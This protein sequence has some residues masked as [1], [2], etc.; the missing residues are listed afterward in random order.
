MKNVRAG[1]VRERFAITQP[2]QGDRIVGNAVMML[3][4]QRAVL[5]PFRFSVCGVNLRKGSSP[6]PSDVN[7]E[8]S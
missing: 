8:R 6:F 5:V 1:S 7:I 4:A 3:G 2:R